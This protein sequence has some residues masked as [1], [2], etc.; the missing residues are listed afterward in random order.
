MKHL[1]P[2]LPLII[3]LTCDFDFLNLN[4]HFSVL[5]QVECHHVFYSETCCF[6]MAI[7]NCIFHK[8]SLSVCLIMLIVSWPRAL[9]DVGATP[10]YLKSQHNLSK[11]W[12]LANEIQT[13]LGMCIMQRNFRC[14]K[15]MCLAN[16]HASM[17]SGFQVLESQFWMKTSK[18]GRK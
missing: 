11:K 8:L 7:N 14:Q 1:N 4:N 9:R 10:L 2:C 12:H 6:P 15:G 13:I 5:H 16:T 18:V 3:F 17:L